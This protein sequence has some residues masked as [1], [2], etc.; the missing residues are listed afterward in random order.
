MVDLGINKK[1][2]YL[3]NQI[4]EGAIAAE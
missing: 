2:Q 4:D 3:Q 1:Q